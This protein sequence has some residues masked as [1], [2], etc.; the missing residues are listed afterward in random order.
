MRKPEISN[1]K[2][3]FYSAIEQVDSPES[4]SIRKRGEKSTDIIRPYKKRLHPIDRRLAE[5]GKSRKWLAGELH[6]TPQS[7]GLYC[8]RKL[9]LKPDSLLTRRLCRV[10]E[11]DLNYLLLGRSHATARSNSAPS[12]QEQSYRF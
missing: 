9:L 6:R 10:L 7:I 12:N 3:S 1:S 2:I 11:V 5:M 8:N 4:S